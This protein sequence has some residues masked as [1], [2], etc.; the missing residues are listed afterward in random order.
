MER[1]DLRVTLP[2][3]LLVLNPG[4]CFI[5][6]LPP[7]PQPLVR[8]SK[9]PRSRQANTHTDTSSQTPNSRCRTHIHAQKQQPV[10]V[11]IH[12][13]DSDLISSVVILI[14]FSDVLTSAAPKYTCHLTG[15]FSGAIIS[16]VV[17]LHT[18]AC[19]RTPAS[20]EKQPL[21]S[22]MAYMGA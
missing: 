1:S 12:K 5:S 22:P 21:S 9:P 20:R 7:S 4:P 2:A 17:S 10:P 18:D 15:C 16:K 6:S 8:S 11:S 3:P 14:H 19:L 13:H